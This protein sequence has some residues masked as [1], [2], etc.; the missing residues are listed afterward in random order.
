MIEPQTPESRRLDDQRINPPMVSMKTKC[1]I[2]TACLQAII[3][4]RG[5]DCPEANA[6]LAVDNAMALIA[7]LERVK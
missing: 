7:E 5:G 1:E 3:T 2:A 6:K 4:Y